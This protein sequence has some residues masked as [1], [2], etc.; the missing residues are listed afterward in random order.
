M[1]QFEHKPGSFSLF[2]NDKGDNA[3][4]P[5]YRGEGK[6]LDGNP[7]EVAAWLKDGANGRYMSCS[8]KPATARQPKEPPK[9]ASG[10]NDA[11]GDIPF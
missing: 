2:R 5:D 7:I 8:I 1:A 4:R 9:A 3:S 6:D 10:F 11:M